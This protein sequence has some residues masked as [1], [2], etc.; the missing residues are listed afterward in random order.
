[1]NQYWTT[2][3]SCN[4]KNDRMKFGLNFMCCS[5]QLSRIQLFLVSLLS[6]FFVIFI[7]I[8]WIFPLRFYQFSSQNIA[9]FINSLKILITCTVVQTSSYYSIIY[10]FYVRHFALITI[11]EHTNVLKCNR[12]VKFL[13]FCLETLTQQVHI[14]AMKYYILCI[15]LLTS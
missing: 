7:E 10:T 4:A 15:L 6:Y 8:A 11:E 2:K 9:T 13:K 12:K 5:Y 1:M 14:F 3:V